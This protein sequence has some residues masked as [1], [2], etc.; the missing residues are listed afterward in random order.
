MNNYVKVEMAAIPDNVSF[1][2]IAAAGF[3]APLDPT[4][5]ECTD[6]KTA[7]SEA[8]TN[9]VIHGYH[10][11]SLNSMITMGLW[12]DGRKITIEISDNGVGIDDIDAVR[13]P[14]F[15]TKPDLERSGMGFT[16]METFMDMVAVKSTPGVGT[17]ITMTKTVGAALHDQ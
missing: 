15:T 8:V 3:I 1:A 13:A 9:A 7:V 14:M 11:H 10:G 2:R 4:V 12:V 6:I 17:V 5:N 16:I